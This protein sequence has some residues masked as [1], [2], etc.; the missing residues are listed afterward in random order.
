MYLIYLYHLSHLHFPLIL[1]VIVDAQ[2][3][4]EDKDADLHTLREDINLGKRAQDQLQATI[5]DLKR[6]VQTRE[7]TVTDLKGKIAELYVQFQ[8]RI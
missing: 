8:V 2:K 4:L 5:T 1:Q 7:T 3:L 6:D